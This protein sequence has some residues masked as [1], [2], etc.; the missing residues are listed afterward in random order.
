MAGVLQ[1]NDNNIGD[2]VGLL[3]E[4]RSVQ[5]LQVVAGGG[6]GGVT[7]FNSRVGAILPVVGDYPV[8]LGLETDGGL[9]QYQL[10]AVLPNRGTLNVAVDAWPSGQFKGTLLN[11]NSV[12]F[13]LAT[14]ANRW[15]EITATV[16][17]FDS[18]SDVAIYG[19][20]LYVMAHQVV[21]VA[22]I[23]GAPQNVFLASSAGWS[24]I[25][26]QAGGNV[27]VT[28]QNL[29]GTDRKYAVTFAQ[30]SADKN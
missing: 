4:D 14:A 1:I 25:A 19:S 23:V 9:T 6:A 30:Q 28:L 8:G 12:A 2:T 18:A 29:S 11:G 22:A 7:S 5:Y 26:T 17:V 10:A 20:K 15:Q 24:W 21:G 16:F 27:V 3:R 13:N